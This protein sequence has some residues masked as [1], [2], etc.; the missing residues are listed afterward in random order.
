[1]QEHVPLDQF[2]QGHIQPGLEYC[3]GWGI[4]LTRQPVLVPH[5]PHNKKN[6]FL[7]SYI[8][9]PSFN[10]YPVFT[11]IRKP[12]NPSKG[13]VLA[14]AQ[15]CVSTLA[16]KHSGAENRGQ[17]LGEEQLFYTH[18]IVPAGRRSCCKFS[19]V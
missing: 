8:N 10:L 3:Q 15:N 6:F 2:A 19:V 4:H 9:L 7:I 14:A 16:Q 11:C 13:G 17:L 5:L 1:M 12:V 18:Q